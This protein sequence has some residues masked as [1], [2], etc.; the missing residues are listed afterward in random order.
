MRKLPDK[1]V[2]SLRRQFPGTPPDALDLL[3]KLL[4]IHPGKRITVEDALVHPFLAS[5]H[6]PRDE[7]VADTP[8][9]FGF[10]N[11][12]LYRVRLQELIWEEVGSFRPSCLPVAPRKTSSSSSRGP[13][14]R[15]AY[16]A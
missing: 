11:Q 2:V 9:D 8:F 3:S 1:P 4:Q 15:R 10:E 7:P 14:E 12:D 5:L 16:E 13:K 6:N